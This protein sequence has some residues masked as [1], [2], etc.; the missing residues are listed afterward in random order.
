MMFYL[1]KIQNKYIYNLQYK[2]NLQKIID[3]FN[4]IIY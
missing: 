4:Y 3:H 2:Y 1:I